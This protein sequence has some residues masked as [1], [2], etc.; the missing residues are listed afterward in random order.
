MKNV[1]QLEKERKEVLRNMNVKEIRK[2]YENLSDEMVSY[3]WSYKNNF[4]GN[5]EGIERIKSRFL[6]L[7]SDLKDKY[8]TDVLYFSS[9]VKS[10]AN[11]FD[12]T[13]TEVLKNHYSILELGLYS[14]YISFLYNF[15]MLN[16]I[17]HHY[18]IDYEFRYTDSFY[19]IEEYIHERFNLDIDKEEDLIAIIEIEEDLRNFNIEFNDKKFNHYRMI[20]NSFIKSLV[21]NLEHISKHIKRYLE[22]E[23]RIDENTIEELVP[24]LQEFNHLQQLAKEKLDEYE[25][26]K[27]NPF[28]KAIEVS[29]NVKME[30]NDYR[31]NY[32]E[33]LKEEDK[34]YSLPLYD[35]DEE[36]AK[37]I[38]NAPKYDFNNFEL[39]LPEGVDPDE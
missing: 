13:N 12:E 25:E 21:K 32:N 4:L 11:E 18:Y 22:L 16:D 28:K 27:L 31:I 35:Y 34:K 19:N 23:E 15:H 5:P 24:V 33:S 17:L 3:F 7:D 29:V 1:N 9:M 39:I 10:L 30:D 26:L 8:K 20:L 36:L 38:A 2:L 37:A 14:N 6:E